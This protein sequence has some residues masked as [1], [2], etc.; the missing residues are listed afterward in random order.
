MNRYETF[1]KACKE[2]KGLFDGD[3]D[4]F[5]FAIFELDESGQVLS[6]FLDE[7]E[8][9]LRACEKDPVRCWTATIAV[10]SWFD[11]WRGHEKEAR[12]WLKN[13]MSVL[14]TRP[15]VLRELGVEDDELP[16]DPSGRDNEGDKA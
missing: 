14:E 2:S 8:A 11:H 9:A 3:V 1:L 12:K 13:M 16:D 15:S 10:L 4:E 6:G 5:V 7:L